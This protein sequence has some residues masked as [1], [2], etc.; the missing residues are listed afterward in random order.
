[1][2][3]GRIDRVLEPPM[4]GVTTDHESAPPDGGSPAGR[5]LIGERSQRSGVE[6]QTQQNRACPLVTAMRSGSHG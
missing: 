5:G 3:H 4:T 1:M 6:S 2:A